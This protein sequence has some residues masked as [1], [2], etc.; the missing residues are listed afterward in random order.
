MFWI[1]PQP[2]KYLFWWK[3]SQASPDAKWMQFPCWKQ[4]SGERFCFPR[5][6]LLF[7]LYACERC[8]GW[9]PNMTVSEG[10]YKR[11]SIWKLYLKSKCVL[12]PSLDVKNR[13]FYK[14]CAWCPETQ[15]EHGLG[16][17]GSDFTSQCHWEL[18]YRSH[19]KDKSLI[20]LLKEEQKLCSL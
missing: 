1:R 18:G 20:R 4:A 5:W 2:Q 14:I 15:K 6:C 16:G 12:S 10:F 8:T 19:L 7:H 11:Y 3:S 9:F 17:R 13:T